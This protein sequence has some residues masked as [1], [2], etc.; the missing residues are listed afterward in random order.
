M[1]AEAAQRRVKEFQDK[2][3]ERETKRNEQSRAW[4]KFRWMRQQQQ[5][6]QRVR[7]A[8][9]AATATR[10]QHQVQAAVATQRERASRERAM[11]TAGWT[12][13]GTQMVNIRKIEN[14]KMG[15]KLVEENSEVLKDVGE[16]KNR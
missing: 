9:A 3:D 5:E 1:K 16:R 6:Q 7:A 15:R 12:T 11:D 8:A 10:H 13:S 2:A 4:R 14:S